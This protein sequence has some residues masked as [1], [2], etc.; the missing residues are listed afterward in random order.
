[1]YALAGLF[2]QVVGKVVRFECLSP[3][4]NPALSC[5]DNLFACTVVAHAANNF[6]STFW[7]TFSDLCVPP[8][9]FELKGAVY[10]Q[11]SKNRL[12]KCLRVMLPRVS[13]RQLTVLYRF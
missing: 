10:R 7:T 13:W 8:P 5:C 6:F 12:V 4:T 11:A 1:M 3:W 2:I 9:L